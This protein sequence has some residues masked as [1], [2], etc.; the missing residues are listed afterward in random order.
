MVKELAGVA[1]AKKLKGFERIASVH[2][3]T[4]PFSTDNGLM[5]PSMKLKRCAR[6][7]FC[8]FACFSPLILLSFPSSSVGCLRCCS[9]HDH[10]ARNAAYFMVPPR[11][12]VSHPPCR[13]GRSWHAADSCIAVP[14]LTAAC[15]PPQHLQSQRARSAVHAGRGCLAAMRQGVWRR[16]HEQTAVMWATPDMQLKRCLVVRRPALQKGFQKQIDE[17]YKKQ[18]AGK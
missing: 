5:T 6:A 13:C 8:L 1:K 12:S 7:C 14:C 18:K 11:V 2:L 3:V 17:M 16:M 4:E 9:R 15:H 10:V